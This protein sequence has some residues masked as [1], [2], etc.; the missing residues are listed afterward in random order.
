MQLPSGAQA[1]LYEMIGQGTDE[2]RM[3]F[4]SDKFDPSALEPDALLADMTF[5]CENNDLVLA[6]GIDAPQHVTVSLADREAEF[7]ILDTDVSQSFEAF[8]IHKTT[9][10]WEAF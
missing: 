2:V 3:R 7:G 1:Y 10:I 5:L 6:G 4:V 8:T 9:C